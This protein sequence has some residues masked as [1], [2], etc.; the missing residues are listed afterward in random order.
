MS[1]QSAAGDADPAEA[2]AAL[3]DDTRVEVLRALWDADGRELSFSELRDAVGMHDSGQFNYHLGKLTERFVS[4]TEDGYRLT[5]AGA[6]V[7]GSVLAGAYRR[8]ESVGPIPLDDPCPACGGSRAFEYE[9]ESANVVCEDCDVGIFLAVPPGVFAGHD[10][11]EFPAVADRY[12]RTKTRKA[13]NGFCPYCE[14]RVRPRL[15]S[16]IATADPNADVP[17]YAEGFPT[18]R[19]ECDRCDEEYAIDLGTAL[20]DEPS[21]VAF[22][23]DRGI[24]VRKP[25]LSRFVADRDRTR[26]LE[27]KPLLASVTYEAGDDHLTLTVDSSLEVVGVDRPGKESDPD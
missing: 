2:F 19:Y 13:A 18:A 10:P 16:D 8:S 23:H 15:A 20:L 26:V 9:D 3:S 5:V 27:R 22:Y 25:P 6:D 11:E 12:L 17:D 14:G 24:D 21:V 7:V 4:K 1:D